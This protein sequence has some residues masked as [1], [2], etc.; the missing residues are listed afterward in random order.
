MAPS[1]PARHPPPLHPHATILAKLDTRRCRTAAGTSAALAHLPCRG[2]W[3]HAGLSA[4]RMAY[5]SVRGLVSVHEL[6]SHVCEKSLL[7]ACRREML[8]SHDDRVETAHGKNPLGTH[9]SSLQSGLFYIART[10]HNSLV[11]THVLRIGRNGGSWHLLPA[12]ALIWEGVCCKYSR[13][14]FSRQ[15]CRVARQPMMP[16]SYHVHPPSLLHH[17]RRCMN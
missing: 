1:Y 5:A 14:G 7:S 6:H 3:T 15:V 16:I 2:E 9:L 11:D 10:S 4:R 8:G 12:G 13:G 17:A